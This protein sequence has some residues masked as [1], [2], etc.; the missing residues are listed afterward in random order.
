MAG[1]F[2]AQQAHTW[3]ARATGL[4]ALVL[5]SSALFAAG[6][7]P[8]GAISPPFVQHQVTTSRAVDMIC[9]AN[10]GS[11]SA[12]SEADQTLT[13]DITAPDVVQP[14]ETY[15]IKIRPGVAIYPGSDTSTGIT[16]TIV[17]VYNQVTRFQLPPNVTINSA[18]L[19][20]INGNI[21]ANADAGY[22]V[23]PANVPSS[24]WANPPTPF[25]PV[26]QLTHD[27]LL[28]IPGTAPAVKFNAT[29]IV[30]FGM[31]GTGTESS[32]TVYAG[33]SAVQPPSIFLNVTAPTNVAAGAVLST[34]FTGSL[35]SGNFTTGQP[36]NFPAPNAITVDQANLTSSDTVWSSPTYVNYVYTT[37]LGGL[38]KI[39]AKAACAPGYES[40]SD[41]GTTPPDYYTGP[42]AIPNGTSPSISDT[43]VTGITS[44]ADG[45]SYAV[46]QVVH[47]DYSCVGME[48]YDGNP[49]DCIGDVPD[50]SPIDTSAPGPFTFTV[51]ATDG[52][53]TSTTSTSYTVAGDSPPVANAGP[54]Q[55]GKHSGDVV[56][57]DGSA[58][59]DPNTGDTISYSW[60]QISG[61]AVS[62]SNPSAVKP[63]F[64]MPTVTSPTGD[65]VVMQLTATDSVGMQSTDT[66]SISSTPSTPTVAVTKSRSGG[67][68]SN[69]CIGDVVTLGT[70]ITNA[71]GNS[72]A[73]YTFAWT[74]TGGRTTSL[75]SSTASNPTYILPPSGA[76]SQNTVCTSGTG[77]VTTTS[78]NCP[79]FSVVVTKTNT[80]KSSANTGLAAYASTLATR[81]VAN[82]GSAQARG[83]GRT[84][85]LDGSASTQ[86]NG[87]AISY[88]WTQTG[89]T[90]VTLSSAAAQKPT[91]TT[92]A[93][94][95]TLT[96]SLT[97]T[98]TQNAVTGTGTS[99][100]T[101]TAATTTVTV[102]ED[103]VVADAGP[104]QTGKLA[105]N[106]ITLTA[107][108]STDP[109]GLAL[110]YTWQ[111][112]SGPS[113]T[114][115]NPN[116]LSPTFTAPAATSPAGYT[117][118]F[119]VTATNGNAGSN[120]TDTDATP[121][122]ITVGASTPTVA[123]TK[124]R[125]GGT[126][127]NF[128]TGD[129]VTLGTT[130]TNP[131]GNSPADYTFVWTQTGGRTTSLSSST[132]SNPTYILPPS[133]AGSQNTACT[134]GTGAVTATS[135]NCPTFSVV[136]TKT[137]TGKS[138]ANTGLAA[139]SSTLA[140][141]P[142]ANAGTAQNVKVGATV[143]LDGSASTQVNGHPISYAWT[144]TAGPAVTLSSTSGQ[145]PTFTAPG[146]AQALTFSLVVTDTQNAVAGTGTNGNTST[147]NVVNVTVADYA[148][149][150]A[151][152]GSDQVVYVEDT[153]HLDGSH[154]S[155][156]DGH[157][158]TFHWDQVG[159][160]SVTLSDANSATPTFT[161]PNRA[162][163]LTFLLTVTDASNPNPA[164]RSSSIQSFVDVHEYAAPTANAGPNQSGINPNGAVQLDGSGS[165]SNSPFPLSYQ[166]TQT[167]GPAVTLSSSTAA[168]PTFTAPT[169]PLT[170]TFKLMVNDTLTDSAPSYVNVDVNGI[171]GL[172]F[173]TNLTG[174]VTGEKAKSAFA[175]EVVNSGALTRT[176][177]SAGLAV[178]ITVNGHAVASPAYSVASRSVSVA[179]HHNT[180]FTLTWN[181]GSSLHAGDVIV[182]KACE[183]F[184]GDV[185]PANDCGT[186]NDPPGAIRIF[187][188]PKW[189][190][191]P[192]AVTSVSTTTTLPIWITNLSSF[193][194]H[195]LRL[196]EN[197]TVRVSVNG[198]PPQTAVNTNSTPFALSPA[199]GGTKQVSFTW[200]HAPLPRRS[201]V[202]VTACA[203]VPG[204]TWSPCASYTVTSS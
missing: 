83:A 87:H 86:A 166:W 193:T 90:T 81:P 124:S 14:G 117:L 2:G 186:V 150:V 141:R 195:A 44:P 85:T 204:N 76:G 185:V 52:S 109:D 154:S 20:P 107:A 138:S 92:P 105:G 42:G 56:T 95:G 152:A 93:T 64:A 133:G 164:L 67:T 155:Q 128:C 182:V 143:T 137:N 30:R 82:A 96:F 119:T 189:Y 126:C 32:G 184:L 122:T 13:Y 147:A 61:P 198:G 3:K 21:D 135:A 10:G 136:V 51:S 27:K 66:V 161:A 19:G 131:D 104:D 7:A 73:D 118:T 199:T 172:D 59:T 77:A 80:G 63:T 113:V 159:G 134:S 125:S 146:T 57:L 5:A 29:N 55:S 188:W 121:V 98:D 68:C 145:K 190:P 142:V 171:A 148:P 31:I 187:A 192:F 103:H 160:Q 151:D 177:T 156:S 183:K 106:T 17:A 37:A 157:T 18:T 200:T 170:L 201:N 34:T 45:G 127:S 70:T 43:V 4:L 97:V 69:F 54:D 149:P 115:S 129:V 196:T 38:I 65:T 102:S 91:F 26:T 116:A 47:A 108:G 39:T 48:H 40:N 179:A 100:N 89:G 78:A 9:R 33:G 28:A 84:V 203:A 15:T 12:N 35:P 94:P 153:V 24:A 46:D 169:G 111:Q 71:D 167:A 197:V 140:T 72:P 144:Q 168:K 158:L 75:S 173:A 16:A 41:L 62:L 79:T 139:Y 114:L 88:A 194:L 181:H 99:G 132:A 120:N 110:S 191:K 22:Y 60:S 178:S 174:T 74:Q 176:V 202:T 58:T 123:V 25:D 49:A 101:S 36:N 8:T 53:G 175:V 6:G 165:T 130:I 180:Q 23:A 11:L 50:G 162:T 112:L 1:R 163:S